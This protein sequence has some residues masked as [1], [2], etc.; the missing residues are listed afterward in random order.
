MTFTI[1]AGIVLSL[2]LYA[3]ICA[4]IGYN[5]WVWLKTTVYGGAYKK[6]YI[7]I[8][9]FLSVSL[10]IG[11]MGDLSLFK[12]IGG[13][14]LVV[15]GYS[16]L[17]LPLINLIVFLTK[18]RA[19]KLAGL[20][21][22]A[23]FL[24]VFIV[25]SFN[26]WSPVVRNYDLTIEKESDLES[27]RIMLVSDTH[28]GPIVGT[29]HLERLVKLVNEEKPDIILIPGDI[30]DDNIEPYL[31]KNMGETMEKIQAPLG[32]YASAGNHDYYGDDLPQIAEEMDK[33]GIN[34]L[35]DETVQIGDSFTIVGR[36][37]LTDENRQEISELTN[38]IDQ[39]LPVI[40]LDHT[41]LELE[42]AEKAGAD[43][44]LSGHTHRGQL[45]PANVIT[46]MIYENDWGYLQQG[47]LH[48]FVSSGFGTWGPPLRIGS[49]SEVMMID[50][51]FE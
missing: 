38:N 21:Y 22:L 34:L 9:I 32:V 51:K 19:I 50:V 45:F 16:L 49:R 10:F 25:G 18:K 2:L 1:L 17:L 48:S 41:P 33:L 47:Q 39:S 7:G 23:F 30:I 40:V 36:H 35:L 13:Y 29:S 46:S 4:Y 42:E 15:V 12:L 31:A 3:G 6:T 26:A 11:Q 20:A 43:V 24:F 37:D 44:I 27:V 8:I 14:W 5:G 28:L